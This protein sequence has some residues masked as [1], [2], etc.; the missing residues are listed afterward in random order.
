M[1]YEDAVAAMN[2]QMPRRVPRTEYSVNMHWELLK[3]VTGIDVTADS[4]ADVK[5]EA[6]LAMD[7]AWDM[8][9]FWSVLIGGGEI[10]RHT[11]MGHAAYMAGGVDY[12][13]AG[14]EAFTDPDEVL[15][16]DPVAQFGIKDHQTLVRRFE[17]H[18]ASNVKSRPFGVNMTGVYVTLIS[19]L[20]DMLGWDMLLLAAGTD[21]KRFGDMTNRYARWVQQYF[22]AIADSN[23]PYVMVHDD[24]V[25]SSGAFLHPD[26]YRQYVFPNHKRYFDPL[27]QAGKKIIFTSDGGFTE[28]IDDIVATG[29][30]GLVMEPMTSLEYAAEKYGQKLVLIG[31]AD[32]RILL[33][34]DKPAIRA[35]VERCMAAG[36]KCPGF[37]MAVG[38]HIP[39]NTPVDACLYYNQL[40]MDMRER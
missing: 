36:K 13:A 32:T 38:N 40:Y 22:D 19:G 1:S 23:V 8:G 4:P 20:I 39:P 28:F 27:R 14:K 9:F 31:N 10:P 21:P 11:D 17:E 2:L 33:R 35:E 6:A 18:Y 15:N 3:T 16:F 7:R 30:D 24:I 34:N 29:V 5:G 37:F 12:H 25:W 26:W